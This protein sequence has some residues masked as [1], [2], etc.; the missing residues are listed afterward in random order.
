[1]RKKSLL[2]LVLAML[3]SFTA[4]SKTQK[5]NK[6]EV[7]FKP[8]SMEA[9]CDEDGTAYLNCITGSPVEIGGEIV[10]GLM[11]PDR[12][13]G[14][15]LDKTGTIT[16]WKNIQSTESGVTVSIS[17][18]SLE[19]LSD[20]YLIFKRKNMAY[21]RYSLIGDEKITIGNVED[22]LIDANGN[23]AYAKEGTVFYLKANAVEA[24]ELGKYDKGTDISICK[25]NI[26][27]ELKSAEANGA[28]TVVFFISDG[29]DNK[30]EKDYGFEELAEYI[31]YGAVLGYGTE[32]GGEM[33]VRS[34]YDSEDEE[35]QAVQ[36]YSSNLGYVNA[37]S[38][39]DEDNLKHIAKSLGV[40]Y[41]YMNDVTKLD[42]IINHVLDNIEVGAQEKTE[43]GQDDTYFYFVIA[44]LVMVIVECI[45]TKKQ[46]S[47]RKV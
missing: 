47:E 7:E 28:Y 16:Y 36:T 14:A 24:E 27:T 35:P 21:Y 12:K 30:S 20:S 34:Y 8:T 23:V 3:L 43:Q 38:K 11:A 25:S 39:I 22:I 10:S 2:I 32:Q 41:V 9:Q 46:L 17:G 13:Q 26:L 33:Y 29:E 40:E 1:M 31:D 42:T 37:I 6:S 15:T 5:S 45:F 4:C 19:N 18:A 44:L